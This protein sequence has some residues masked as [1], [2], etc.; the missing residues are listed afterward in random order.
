MVVLLLLTASSSAQGLQML[1]QNALEKLAARDKFKETGL[2]TFKLRCS[3]N[4]KCRQ[5]SCDI[6]IQSSGQELVSSKSELS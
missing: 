3:K 4:L 6:N 2:A 5:K 1:Q